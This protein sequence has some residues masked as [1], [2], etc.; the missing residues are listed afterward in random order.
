M[1][2]IFLNLRQVEYDPMPWKEKAACRG[3]DTAIFFP[4]Q[5]QPN[6]LALAVC[7]TCPVSQEC[8]NFA[9]S[10]YERYGVWGGKSERKR[11]AI[12]KEP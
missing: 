2:R 6:T 12:R 4:E 5:G 1:T 7:K 11:R 8:L 9:L 10:N 3:M